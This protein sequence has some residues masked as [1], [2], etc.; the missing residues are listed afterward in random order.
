MAATGAVAA[1]RRRAG[2]AARR[3]SRSRARSAF[4]CIAEM[5]KLSITQVHQRHR[6]IEFRQ[7]L[8]TI[9]A[10]VPRH[11]DVHVITD[12]YGTH[13]TP[14]I[15]NWSAKRRRFHVHFNPTYGSWLYHRFAG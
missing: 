15:R 13:K 3:S 7:F 14:L 10:T 5:F 6:S 2:S 12:N 8:D 9:E 1:W 4:G 11:L